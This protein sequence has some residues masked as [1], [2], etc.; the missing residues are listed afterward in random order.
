MWPGGKSAI[1]DRWWRITSL[2]P[3]LLPPP[4]PSPPPSTPPPPSPRQPPEG[5]AAP[6]PHGSP[7]IGE[8]VEAPEKSGEGG[9]PEEAGQAGPRSQ[10]AVLSAIEEE[11]PNRDRIA[12]VVT[13]PCQET[14]ADALHRRAQVRTGFGKP[15]RRGYVDAPGQRHGQR[16]VSG[17]ADP[18]VVKQDKSSGGSV[19]T[20]RQTSDPQRVGQFSDE[21]PVGA[22]KGKQ[23]S[24]KAS[25]HPPPPSV[26]Q[27]RDGRMP[28]VQSG[29]GGYAALLWPGDN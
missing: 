8:H 3:C 9:V 25:C 14:P 28:H 29:G 4:P 20:T 27:T 15:T 19:D 23:L 7:S 6:S 22:A 1:F 10:K 18:R 16:P 5:Q 12:V 24:T 26:G 21:R 17:T 2:L 13:S 11:R